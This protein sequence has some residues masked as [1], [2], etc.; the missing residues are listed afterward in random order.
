[1]NPFNLPVRR[2][3][4]TSMLF[5]GL[6]LLGWIAWNRIPVELIPPVSGDE[7][8]VSFNRPGSEP[9]VVE[10]EI[11]LPLQARVAELPDVDETWAELRGASGSFSVRFEPGTDLKVR[12]LELRRL[13]AELSREQPQGTLIDVSSQDLTII[14]RF[15]MFVQV[16]GMEDRNALLDFV[17]ERVLPRLAAVSGA[18]RVLAGGGAPK[19]LTV[20]IDPDRTA[21]EGL[22]PEQVTAALVRSV[23]RLQFLGGVEDEAG[24]SAVLLDG[25]PEGVWSLSETRITAD[26]PTLLRH[27]A[28]V[29]IGTGREEIL[30]RVN[31]QP[32]VA[33]VVFQ[34]EG[35]NLIRLGRRLRAKLDELT[36]EFRDYGIEFVINFDAAELVE[37]QLV[38]LER[39]AV[40]GFLTAL[41]VLF[42][43]LRQLRAVMVV[44]VAVPVSLLTALAFLYLADQS[45]NLIT[46]FGLAVGI[47]MLVDNSIVVYEAVQ[48]QL[49]H[50]AS[51]D[52]AAEYGVRRTVRAI[53]AA[54]LTNGIVFLPIAFADFGD[55]VTRALLVVMA[56]AILL[57]MIG[58]VLVAVGLVPLLARRL[59]APAAIARLAWRRHRRQA[60]GGLR[61]PDRTRELF[62]G[63]LKVALRR[64]TVWVTFVVAAVLLTVVGALPWV[65]VGTATQEPPEAQ[66]VRFSVSIE[67]GQSM[68]RTTGV[69]ERLESAA[70]ALDGL[71]LVESVIREEGGSMTVHLLPKEERPQDVDASRVRAVV[72]QAAQPLDDVEVNSQSQGFG[73][74]GSRRGGRSGG[75]GAL[76]GT[77][78]A[79]TVLS[80]PDADVLTRMARDI[81]QQLQSIPEIGQTSI[82]GNTG[83]HEI[84]VMPDSLALEAF[85]LTADQVLPALSIVRRE[86]LPLRV[87]FTLSDG[88]EIPM[89]VRRAEDDR[90]VTENL[91]ELRL[92]TPAGVLP[93]SALATVRKM[94]PPPTIVHHNGRREIGVS[95]RLGDE[96]PSTGPSRT[97][98]EDQIRE[99]IQSVHR[100]AGYTI[101]APDPDESF[102]WFKKILVPVVLLLFAAL[103]LT[104]ES[105]T[106]PVLV[107]LSLPLTVLGATWALVLGDM[108]A[109]YMALVGALALV[110]LTVN[111]AILLVDRMQQRAW[112]G[113][114]SA[115]AAAL[116][117]VRER[118]RPVL[119]TATTTIAGL[120]PM[121]IATGRENEIWPPFATVVIGG[122]ATSTLLT[123][124]VVPVGFVFLHRLDRL[125]GKLGPWV[126]IGWIGAT[127]LV[128]APLIVT[129]TISSL[130]WQIVTTV[131]V[132]AA[133]LGGV[134]LFFRRPEIPEPEAEEGGPPAVEVRHLHKIYGQPGPV[135]RAWRVEQRFADAVRRFGGSAF[136]PR[137]A[138]ERLLPLGLLLGFGVLWAFFVVRS[139]GWRIVWVFVVAALVAAMLRQIR[140]ARGRA[141]ALGRVELGGPENVVAALVPWI[142]MAYLALKLRVE[143]WVTDLSAAGISPEAEPHFVEE[144]FQ[145]RAWVLIAIAVLLLLVQSGRRTAV[146]IAR[147]KLSVEVERG[148]RLRRL[149]TVWRRF[150][151]ASFG[152]DLPREEVHALAG[153]N[154]RATRG[155]LGILGPNGA[156]KTTLLRM[157]TGILEPSVGTVHIGGV[158]LG[159]LQRFLARWVGYLPQDFGLPKD[160]TGREYLEYY[161]LL[162]ELRPADRRR[163]RIDRL[164]QEVGLGERADEK[165]GGY[166]GG[167]RQR[168]AV[169]RTLL[170]LPPVIV[171]DEPTVGLDP[172]ERIRFR[173]L[174]SRLAEER[175]VL[176]S[177]HVV[178]DVEV[179]CERV[180]VMARG[181]V[182]FDGEPAGLAAAAEGRVWVA[183]LPPGAD[184]ALRAG[185]LVV[186]QVPELDGAVRSRLLADDRPASG[187]EPVAPTLEDGYLWLVRG[188]SAA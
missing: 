74:G 116:G 20:L 56:L 70:M 1:M 93:L 133:M 15:A 49:E 132:A 142:A 179:A 143:A 134:V 76:L 13:A 89:T 53:L 119:M 136:E 141:D 130:T 72:R 106:L 121:T 47:G 18:S 77:A 91:S 60:L 120:A 54:T 25:R 149:R 166:S 21:A 131:L 104:F 183:T 153:V 186:D 64:P 118:A 147:G 48:R 8:F 22:L 146:H 78:P 85:G 117:A 46:L 160:L 34:E 114:M 30:F 148:R 185:T 50:G 184:Q 110:G 43:F 105:L 84:R 97:A 33:M 176:F 137:E 7:L 151:R 155:M 171:V 28:D 144:P 101:E 61:P 58:S 135:G 158:R 103:A 122:L 99:A 83:Q 29:E 39:L 113:G 75:V 127:T 79:M 112:G 174:L 73:G 88:R 19:E 129:D 36:E 14:S 95:Y 139:V 2:P 156:G 23:R 168:V 55:G 45:I 66:Q 52:H 125:F 181:G 152:L 62:S 115:G 67:G 165:I 11:L 138:L 126:V 161:A 180:I 150:A 32:T 157:L 40:F 57:P 90:P 173:N 109:D 145:L 3:V 17:E 68:E 65:A 81:E 102:S 16:L 175:V 128:M 6:L 123:L 188:G 41:G 35:A 12:E 96:A 162:Y 140:I 100:P 167:M 92:A 9:E 182:V 42:L 170:R 31:G 71:K 86:G 26:R 38:R 107:L 5:S 178:E 4:A 44:A 172:R 111:P 169:A 59:A 80:G 63:M 10:R 164:L 51:A 124:L 177:T 163:E 37:E 24:R 87:G 159:E 82:D 187:A 108:P 98:L 27:V 154:F 94:P 69:F